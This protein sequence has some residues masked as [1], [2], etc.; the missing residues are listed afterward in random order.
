L[1]MQAQYLSLGKLLMPGQDTSIHEK[2]QKRA[3]TSTIPFF[4]LQNAISSGAQAT[5]VT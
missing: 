5:A 4:K 3:W 1:V 2:M